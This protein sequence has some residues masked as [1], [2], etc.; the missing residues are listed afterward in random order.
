LAPALQDLFGAAADATARSCQFIKR[1]RLFCGSS[2]LQTCVFTWIDNPDASLEQFTATAAALGLDVSRQAIDQ[3]LDDAAEFFRLMLERSLQRAFT[4]PGR[5][6]PLLEPFHG[7]YLDDATHLRLPPELA[8]L[9]P[10]CGGVTADAGAATMKV[11]LR[12]EVH[13]ACV[14]GLRLSSS[15]CGDTT[16]AD[17][18]P[19]PPRGALRLGDLGFFKLPMLRD[20]AG[21]G[22]FFISKIKQGTA[23]RVGGRRLQDLAGWLERQGQNRIDADAQLGGGRKARVRCRLVAWRLSDEQAARRRAKLL[24][25]AQDKGYQASA[26]ALTMCAW[27]VLVTNV[28]RPMLSGQEVM[29]VYRVRWQ[30]EMSHPH[31]PSSDSLYRGRWAA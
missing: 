9:F 23:L 24:E 8:A 20:L 28:P 17:E 15:R 6:L 19:L 21:A 10:G 2:F 13:A 14:A 7:V 22:V 27:L 11:L 16:L 26:A 1:Q 5:V 31:Y 3:R 12:W 4:T 18:L 29:E 30:I 25:D